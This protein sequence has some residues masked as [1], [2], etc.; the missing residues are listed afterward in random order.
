VVGA[1]PG[2]MSAFESFP[3][4]FLAFN[5]FTSAFKT[6]EPIRSLESLPSWPGVGARM[7]IARFPRGPMPCWIPQPTALPA[8]LAANHNTPRAAPNV[9]GAAQYG[10]RAHQCDTLKGNAV[11]ERG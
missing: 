7:S 1:E 9:R 6:L 11:P 4:D 8:V 5:A 2:T 3:E 10:L